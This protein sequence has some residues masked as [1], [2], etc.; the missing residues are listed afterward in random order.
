LLTSVD[1]Q[2]INFNP[3]AQSDLSTGTLCEYDLQINFSA[4]S[5]DN[6]NRITIYFINEESLD[7]ILEYPPEDK[8][9]TFSD[10]DDEFDRNWADQNQN[11]AAQINPD[12][13]PGRRQAIVNALGSSWV[14]ANMLEG[15]AYQKY[16]IYTNPGST[17]NSSVPISRDTII[18]ASRILI[19]GEPTNSAQNYD[20][21]EIN[22]GIESPSDV[23]GLPRNQISLSGGNLN[24]KV[25]KSYNV[26]R[27]PE[28]QY[29]PSYVNYQVIGWDYNN[30][31]GPNFIIENAKVSTLFELNPGDLQNI[32]STASGGINGIHNINL[33]VFIESDS[34]GASNIDGI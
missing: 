23:G 15:F 10:G 1:E 4:Q 30:W 5:S 25:V 19:K 8:P 7:S 11:Y 26:S 6:N 29:N 22:F 28:V 31:S 3:N 12:R 16:Q 20:N 18:N 32:G 14:D 34:G 17:Q 27:H 33:G 24:T 9:D 21:T 13:T 2:A